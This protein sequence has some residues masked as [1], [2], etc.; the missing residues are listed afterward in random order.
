MTNKVSVVFLGKNSKK[1]HHSLICLNIYLLSVSAL[2]SIRALHNG[3]QEDW[4][5]EFRYISY[6]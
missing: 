4:L 5:S 2:G 1:S 3:A 6:V